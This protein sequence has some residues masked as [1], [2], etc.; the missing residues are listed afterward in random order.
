MTHPH[1]KPPRVPE[2]FSELGHQGGFFRT[3]GP[4]YMT[5]TGAGERYGMWLDAERHGNVR[6]VVH[7]GVLVSFLDQFLGKIAWDALADRKAATVSLNTE[8][9]A[10]ALP[11]DWIEGEGKVVRRTSSLVFLRG[12]VL[13]G[14]TVLATAQGVWMVIGPR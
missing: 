2:G 6:D 13:R 4:V 7:G 12:R 1:A 14:E 10:P 3:I 5:R 11:G 8:F 9:L